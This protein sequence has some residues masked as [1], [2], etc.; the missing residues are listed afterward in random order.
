LKLF[1]SQLLALIDDVTPDW[2]IL[3]TLQGLLGGADWLLQRDMGPINA[4]M[5]R[6]Q[7]RVP[8]VAITHSPRDT[9]A[10]RAAGTITQ[11]ANY[12]TVL[13]FQKN[14][15]TGVVSAFGDS[16]MG[17][18]LNFDLRLITESVRGGEGK[19]TEEVRKIVYESH[20]VTKKD[21]IL[22]YRT[23]NPKASTEDIADATGSTPQHVRKV[24][25]T[26]P[27]SPGPPSDIFVEQEAID[28]K[29]LQ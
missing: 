2:V 22:A 1:E 14:A 9:K 8:L 17:V 13:H 21:L 3:S 7:R 5:V 15:T 4:I 26:K 25:K 18:E 16:K 29:D 12:L 28:E 20:R 11:D 24:L 27:P 23:E 6:L 19:I 10:R